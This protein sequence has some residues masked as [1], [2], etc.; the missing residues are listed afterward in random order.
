MLMLLLCSTTF[1]FAAVAALSVE[2]KARGTEKSKS[3][4][5]ELIKIKSE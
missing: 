5:I 2:K 4:E 1:I 3:A